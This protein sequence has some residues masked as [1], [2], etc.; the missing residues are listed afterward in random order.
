MAARSRY[1]R[2]RVK[3]A[4]NGRAVEVLSA[5]GGLS[6]DLLDGQHHPCPKCGGTDRFRMIDQEAGAV[7]CNHCLTNCGDL[8]S[9]VQWSQGCSF[10]EAL[11]KIA[12]YVGVGPKKKGE[13]DPTEKLAFLPWEEQ[14]GRQWCVS[15]KPVTHE[16]LL[17]AHARQATYRK[18]HSVIVLPV[19]PATFEPKGAVGYAM[20]HA[21]GGTLPKFGPDGQVIL[22]IKTKVAEGSKAGWIGPIEKL[23]AAKVVW[24]VEGISDLLS[25]LSLA[26]PADHCVLTNPFGTM[27]TPRPEL[28]RMLAGKEV[29]IIHDAD[30]PGE[31]GRSRWLE[32]IR[33]VASGIRNVRLK[34]EIAE[35]HGKDI[36]DWL[37]EIG[38]A[39]HRDENTDLTEA[40]KE[41]G[42]SALLALAERHPLEQKPEGDQGPV[43]QLLEA[44]DDPHRLAEILLRNDFAG[45]PVRNW[46]EDWYVW[47]A[48]AWRR[49]SD[50]D[51]RPQVN[52]AIKSEFNRLHL[53]D[54]ETKD[55]VPH[56]KKV[57]MGLV[58]NV[59]QAMA[60]LCRVSEAIEWNCWLADQE[61]Q[62]KQWVAM[63]NGVLQIDRLLDG[64]DDV[65]IDHVPTWWSPVKLP[66]AFD[67]EAEC[68]RWDAFLERNLEGDQ[69]R[70]AILQEWMGY[71]LIPKTDFQT[72]LMLEGEGANGKSVICA[73]AEALVGPENA[74]HVPLESFGQRFAL[75]TTLGK[76]LNVSAE[77]G[78]IDRAAEGELKKF[79]AGDR[80]L[81][82]RKGKQPVEGSPTARVIFATNTRPRFVD[83]SQGL[84]R[85]MI[86]IPLGV[87]VDASERVI[88]MDKADWW[89]DQGEMP[90][91]FCW[92][93]AGLHRLLSQGRFSE[94]KL[95]QE[96]IREYQG[97]TNPA[98]VFLGDECETC[99]PHGEGVR[100]DDVYKAYR[101][102]CERNNHRALAS[103]NFGKEIRKVFPQLDR[104]RVSTGKREWLYFGVRLIS[105]EEG[106]GDF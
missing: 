37:L 98:Q 88:G 86:L 102:W 70:I 95:V 15:K 51:F 99:S 10:P 55:E 103:N 26:L 32:A 38:V 59:M 53:V 47:K 25:L 79:T 45:G 23:A 82:D 94:S 56:V 21:T 5:V 52:L 57:T 72:F 73:V 91:I 68:P 8:F 69:E 49:V 60:G 41:I 75:T 93:L 20:V 89:I 101:E 74:S 66:Y 9:A 67:A 71:L 6:L 81:F 19:W 76:L 4:V 63:Q 90:G 80:M 61:P 11:E 3:D 84:W 39:A 48:A 12:V 18:H 83:R 29:R 96:A 65:L 64:A 97:E 33:A 40:G 17:A 46:R 35:T 14:I 104:K 58:S 16:A 50:S 100:C 106:S 43:T 24:K 28:V 44:D 22:Q 1:D 54:Q 36:R 2:D 78:E 92:A 105:H 31:E 87:R 85:R 77:I 27:E 13:S 34:Y 62:P 42:R 7:R 30:K